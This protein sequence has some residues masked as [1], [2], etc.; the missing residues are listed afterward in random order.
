MAAAAVGYPPV[1][2]GVSAALEPVLPR[3]STYGRAVMP[4]AQV[5]KD[6]TLR[7][8]VTMTA[9]WVLGHGLH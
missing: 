5:L 9:P 2:C 8:E 6:S 7:H 1:A 4:A 3:V